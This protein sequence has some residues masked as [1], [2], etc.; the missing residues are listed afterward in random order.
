MQAQEDV[1]APFISSAKRARAHFAR[2]LGTPQSSRAQNL[3]QWI[4]RALRATAPELGLR[5]TA[6]GLVLGDHLIALL[7][8]ALEAWGL[9]PS[10]VTVDEMRALIVDAREDLFFDFG[11]DGTFWVGAYLGHAPALL[12]PVE[13]PYVSTRAQQFR[14]EELERALREHADEIAPVLLRGLFASTLHRARR[15]STS[16][17]VRGHPH[18]EEGRLERIAAQPLDAIALTYRIIDG[19]WMRVR[20][21]TPPLVYR[22]AQAPLLLDDDGLCLLPPPPPLLLPPLHPALVYHR[23]TLDDMQVIARLGDIYHVTDNLGSLRSILS[24]K[25]EGLRVS[26]SDGMVHMWPSFLR[27]PPSQLALRV[28][29]VGAILEHNLKFYLAANGVVLCPSPIPPSHLERLPPSSPSPRR[30]K[31]THRH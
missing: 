20:R 15:V 28:D 7:S 21:H 11:P 19:A 8:R 3:T 16:L 5:P 18:E 13:T 29:M 10:I 17:L 14:R 31:M 12:R 25:K 30:T 22:P 4:L 6:D 1:S 26:D 24:C 9:T 2:C 27:A 23:I